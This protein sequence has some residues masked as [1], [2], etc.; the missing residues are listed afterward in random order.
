MERQLQRL[1]WPEIKELVPDKIDTA[2]LPVGTVEAHGS[3][4]VGTDNFIPE[5][6]ADGIAERVEALIAPTINYGI[7]KSLYRYSGGLTI[8]PENFEAYLFDVL[9]SLTETGF[10]N[11]IIMNGHGGNNS[12][13]KTVAHDFHK[14]HRANIGVIH[15]WALCGKMTEEFFG[16]VGGHGG[17][18]E[19]AMVM[20]VDPDLVDEQAYDPEMAYT[21]VP[22]ADVYPVP[23]TI[24]LY[25]EN[26]G[27]PEFDVDRARQY[28]EQV[29]AQVGEFVESV[30]AR[31][32]KFGL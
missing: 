2:I 9:T 7:T 29:V 31:W 4:C 19:T 23:G 26:E 6:I 15:W 22:G 20:A 12:S 13:L 28:R 25:K 1:N 17:T 11:I 24:L 21:F 8:K 27:Y 5:N 18:D 14:K 32:R 30:I 16:H 10:K 3:S